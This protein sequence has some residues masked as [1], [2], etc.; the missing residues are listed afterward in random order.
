MRFEPK[1]E[2]QLNNFNLIEEGTYDYEVIESI[3]SCCKY[4]D[5]ETGQ[6]LEQIKLTLLIIDKL[7]QQR[8]IK[9]FLHPKMIHK[10]K[11]FCDDNG[12]SIKYTHGELNA[13]D[14]F[15]KKGKLEL[16]IQKGKEIQNEPGK[17]YHDQNS[18]QDY[19]VSEK[20]ESKNEEL[21]DDIPF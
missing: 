3:D 6:Y 1:T 15:G 21:N 18:V 17:Y 5:K 19:I 14:C 9:D 12:L 11:H 7:G 2:D 16:I 20:K 4:P 8:K 13:N 10:I